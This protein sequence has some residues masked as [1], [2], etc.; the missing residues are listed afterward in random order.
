MIINYFGTQFNLRKPAV[1]FRF[2]KFRAYHF[3]M[4]RRIATLGGFAGVLNILNEQQYDERI[5]K[6]TQETKQGLNAIELRV[7]I[8]RHTVIKSNLHDLNAAQVLPTC[9]SKT[10]HEHQAQSIQLRPPVSADQ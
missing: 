1:Q 8:I 10:R 2:Q 6:A 7:H 9:S 5:L 3:G 4:F